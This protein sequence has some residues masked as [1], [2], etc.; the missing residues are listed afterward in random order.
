MNS[1]EADR[2]KQMTD[3]WKV[4]AQDVIDMLVASRDPEKL[5]QGQHA[6]AHTDLFNIDH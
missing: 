3:R 1:G 4:A 5:K 2:T 6:H